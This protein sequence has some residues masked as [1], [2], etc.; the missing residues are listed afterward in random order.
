MKK[1]LLWGM[2]LPA[3]ALQ[4][5]DIEYLEKIA[6]MERPPVEWIWQEMDRIWDALCLDNRSELKGQA[7]VDFYAH[8]VWVVNGVF[9]ATDPVSVRHRD[10]I[11]SYVSRLRVGRVADYGGGFGELAKKLSVAVPQVQIDI[12]EP[13]PSKLGMSR[14]AGIAGIQ[15]TKNFEGQYDC[16]IAQDVLEHVERPLQLTE[17]LV[18]STKLGGYLIFANCFYPVIKC[19]LPSTFYLRHTFSW[20]VRGMGLKYEG[21]VDGANHALV[22]RKVGNSDKTM[23]R[24]LGTLAKLAGPLLNMM[25]SL[26][27]TTLRKMRK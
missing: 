1:I 13:Y 9:T 14:V 3:D 22:F 4:Q 2:R 11:A 19:H 6:E 27:G 24:F 16:I 5:V 26:L 10:S 25:A 20:V 18:N 8:P 21:R 7:I 17:Q 12:V 23:T 15:F